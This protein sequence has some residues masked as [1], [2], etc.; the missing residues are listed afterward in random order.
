MTD[1]AGNDTVYSFT[2]PDG[3]STYI[4]EAKYYTGSSQSGT[5]LKTV[6]TGWSFQA[7]NPFD[8]IDNSNIPY[9]AVPTSTKTTWP[10]GL[11]SEVDY[12][13]DSGA[14][15]YDANPGGGSGY[16]LSYGTQTFKKGSS[17]KSEIQHSSGSGRCARQ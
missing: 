10:T 1:P 4:S 8:Y 17:P 6:D 3:C 16:A 2:S 5:L 11:V 13:Y 14:T 7:D 9:S 12:T 15:F